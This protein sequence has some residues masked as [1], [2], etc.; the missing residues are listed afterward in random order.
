M[1]AA[2][3]TRATIVPTL[4]P[5][6]IDMKQAAINK[7]REFCQKMN[8]LC[9]RAQKDD[10]YAVAS[11]LAMDSGLFMLYKS[12]TSIEG[13]SKA[14]NVEELL[15]SVKNYVEER[16]HEMFEEMQADGQIADGVELSESDLPPVLLNDFLENVSLL[17][18]VDVDD[19]EDG[20]NKVALMTVHSSKGLEF[21]YVFVAGME[22][23]IF[24]SGGF[25]ASDTEIEEER[26]LAYVGITRAKKR[27]YLSNA[28]S[29][30]LFGRTERSR[31][32]RFLAEIPD[33]LIELKN[34]PISFSSYASGRFGG[35]GGSFATDRPVYP[36]GSAQTGSRDY[37]QR[38]SFTKH[39]SNNNSQ[40]YAIGHRVRHKAFG[41]GLIIS[42]VPMANDVMLEIA[43]D[44]VGT[45]RIMSNFAKLEII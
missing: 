30:M 6:D 21:P 40:Q 36:S 19:D 41:E 35:F 13:Q 10:A 39:I 28:T 24:P 20:S 18:A 43:F 31:S 12:D 37:N 9:V 33:N 26:R 1:P 11:A 4:V 27:L 14:A 25:L 45:K 15:N 34:E 3:G 38:S 16:H 17:S 8:T 23:N 32:S 22:E 2:I 7:I 44:K 5:M 42:A 29:R